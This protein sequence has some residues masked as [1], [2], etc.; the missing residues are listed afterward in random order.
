MLAAVSNP[1][2]KI[3]GQNADEIFAATFREDL[4]VL[5]SSHDRRDIQWLSMS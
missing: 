4:K 5:E 3:Q 1:E 2:S